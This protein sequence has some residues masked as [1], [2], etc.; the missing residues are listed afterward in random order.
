MYN[1][2]VSMYHDQGQIA[3]KL[4][5]FS[6][7]VTVGAGFPYAISTPAH[8]T[9]FDIAGKGVADTEAMERAIILAAQIAGWRK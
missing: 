5:G 3:T 9:A 8:G 4:M 2:V 1:A 7:G 6:E